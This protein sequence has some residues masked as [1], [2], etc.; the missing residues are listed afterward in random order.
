MGVPVTLVCPL[1]TTHTGPTVYPARGRYTL[2]RM[3]TLTVT[4]SRLVAS[5]WSCGKHDWPAVIVKGFTFD[6]WWGSDGTVSFLNWTAPASN[7]H[8]LLSRSNN[9]CL[10]NMTSMVSLARWPWIP[11][12]WSDLVGC[13]LSYVSLVRVELITVYFAGVEYD[14]D[15][16]HVI[17]CILQ[18][19][20]LSYI[21]I[22]FN[23]HCSHCRIHMN[24]DGPCW[25][26][27]Q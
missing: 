11:W 21:L 9:V 19:L 17:P 24:V 3:M 23:A 22:V 5:C 13:K 20:H 25:K 27:L 14:S 12:P 16:I 15:A 1:V 26:C 7:A 18:N 2:P 6:L 10:I 4:L 8:T